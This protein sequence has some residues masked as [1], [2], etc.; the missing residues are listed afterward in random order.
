MPNAPTDVI[1]EGSAWL[2]RSGQ[3]MTS[4]HSDQQVRRSLSC[5]DR[6]GFHDPAPAT[7]TDP[8]CV[9]HVRSRK[10]DIRSHGRD[11]AEQMSGGDSAR[12]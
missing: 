2:L 4:L 5:P 9:A 11:S 10:E 12:H 7:H 6:A 3:Q 1:I 8:Y